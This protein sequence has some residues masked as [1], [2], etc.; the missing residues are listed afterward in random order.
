MN[1]PVYLLSFGQKEDRWRVALKTAETIHYFV[2]LSELML[3]LDHHH[4]TQVLG[5]AEPEPKLSD[6]PTPTA[7]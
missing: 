6:Q 2:T 3:F 5:A 7:L 1:Q 4:P